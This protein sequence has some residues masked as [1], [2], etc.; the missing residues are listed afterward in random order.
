MALSF[1]DE[2]IKTAKETDLA[3]LVQLLGYGVIVKAKRIWLEEHD[4]LQILENKF[5]WFSRGFGGTSID[6]V[7]HVPERNQRT[8]PE[9]VALILDKL[10]LNVNQTLPLVPVLQINNPDIEKSPIVLPKAHSDCRRVFAYLVKTRGIAF[11]IVEKMVKSNSLYEDQNH[12]CVFVGRD[13]AGIPRSAFVRGT[14]SIKRFVK[15]VSGSDKSYTFSFGNA[16]SS[17]VNIYESAIDALSYATIMQMNGEDP[18]QQMHLVCGG[19]SLNVVQRF[20]NETTTSHILHLRFDSDKAGKSTVENCIQKFM[21]HSRVTAIK[22]LTPQNAKDFNDELLELIALQNR[23]K[24][25][26]R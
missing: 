11:N 26:M 5:Y 2:Q 18:F 6:F 10:N 16:S 12:N 19:T 13:K 4:S 8:F 25:M 14:L 23:D 1:T 20:L 3:E 24:E 9:A 7:M 17:I 15:E 21:G 22:D